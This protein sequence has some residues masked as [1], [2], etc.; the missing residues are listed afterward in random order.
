[1][2]GIDGEEGRLL[3]DE[4]PIQ[5]TA[6]TIFLT[7]DGFEGDE[8]GVGEAIEALVK[9]EKALLVTLGR[10]HTA[11]VLLQGLNNFNRS[12]G[13]CIDPSPALGNS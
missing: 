12:I 9:D 10:D 6:E 8:L 11:Q 13:R 1:V 4:R 2:A 5:L 3:I 7:A